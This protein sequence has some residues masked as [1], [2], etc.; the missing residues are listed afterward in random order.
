MSLPGA[1]L[2]W[3]T[4]PGNWAGAGGIPARLLE[5][6]CYSGIVL[7]AALVL[8]VPLGLWVGHTGR[9]S[10]V[11]VGLA[12]ALR[13]LPT[14]GLLTLFT[15][16]M[17]LG[18]VPPLLALVLMAVPPILS[19]TYAGVANVSP[20]LKDAGTAMGMTGGQVLARVELPNA[21]PV[22]L[23]G[24]RNAAL[25]VV[26]TVT[27]VAYINLGGLGRYLIDGLAVRDY[28]RMLGSVVLVA[29]LALAVDAVL[30]L[31]QRLST[32]RGLRLAG[33]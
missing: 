33:P 4:D 16:L 31:V 1:A 14:L 12:G 25:Q 23:G 15:L 29:L 27:V 8:A 11:V 7:A 30:A 6:L 20:A 28:A 21:A 26:A 24:I 3:L 19:G 13:A 17:G 22:V 10:G 32:S 9:G 18:L 5:H 2:A